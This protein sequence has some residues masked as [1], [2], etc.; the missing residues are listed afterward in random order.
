MAD[1]TQG[2]TARISSAKAA[3]K[4]ITGI[5]AANPPV[6]T[7]TAHGYANGAVI[8]ISGVVGMT[9]VNGR[10]FTVANQTANTFELKGVNGT[11]F[12]PYQSGGSAFLH[13]MTE[14][15]EVQSV[16]RSGGDAERIETTHMKSEARQYVAGLKNSGD[17]SITVNIDDTGPGQAALRGHIGTGVSTAMSITKPS[18]RVE[19]FLVQMS[20]FDESLG[21]N[22]IHQGTFRGFVDNDVAWYT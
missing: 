19:T 14:I 4:T 10:A 15:E 5:T 2:S 21:V 13:T 3:A 7:A 11:A 22:A 8:E 18:G 12:T 20:G 1:R 16:S 6:V 9:Q 17:V